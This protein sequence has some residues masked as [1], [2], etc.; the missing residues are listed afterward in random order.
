MNFINKEKKA[1]TRR[2]FFKQVSVGTAA[3]AAASGLS[4][5]SAAAAA[6]GRQAVMGPKNGRFT[7][8]VKPIVF[9]DPGSGSIRPLARM[10]GGFLEGENVNLDMSTVVYGGKMGKEPYGPHM[11]DFDQLLYFMGGDCYNMG[12]LNAEIELC[13]GKEQE[14]QLINTTTAVYIPRGLPHFPAIV[15]RMNKRFY[16]LEISLAPEYKET[17][18]SAG[19]VPN[20]IK[21]VTKYRS[22]I[23]RPAFMRKA[24]GMMNP[25][26]RDDSGGALA[27]ITN[28]LFPTLIMCE[29]LINSPYRFPNADY[30]THTEPE[31]IIF[32]G[33]DPDDPTKLGGEVELYMGKKEETERYIVTVPIVWI[34]PA[35]VPHCPLIVTKVDKPFIFTDIRPFGTGKGF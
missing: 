20:E 19:P 29:S 10:D 34:V 24:P 4:V 14:K 26:S 28:K 32:M 30:H 17:Q 12:E 25:D 2:N 18:V 35:G 23:T 3:V 1:T 15:R 22:H 6:E 33:G 9:Q 13:L 21:R 5:S 16:Y 31:F 8:Y 7:E 11:H 27:S